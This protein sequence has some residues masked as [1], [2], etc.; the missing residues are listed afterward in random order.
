[1]MLAISICFFTV[2]S[3]QPLPEMTQPWA[4]S[5]AAG[6]EYANTLATPELYAV[7]IAS[8]DKDRP[9]VPVGNGEGK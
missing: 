7:A 4:G 9:C 2:G 8:D 3:H 5:H 6:V 1:M